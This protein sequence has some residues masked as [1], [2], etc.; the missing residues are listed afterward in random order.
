MTRHAESILTMLRGANV[1]LVL[2][3]S[4]ACRDFVAD[5]EWVDVEFETA[6]GGGGCEWEE[7][8]LGG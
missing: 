3:E 7:N 1:L 4:F 6:E 5:S 2:E 8:V